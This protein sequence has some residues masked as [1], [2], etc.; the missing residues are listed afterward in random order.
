VI[1]PPSRIAVQRD[2]PDGFPLDG[3]ADVAAV[4]DVTLRNIDFTPSRLQVSKGTTVVFRWRD[5][6]T[7]HDVT[8]VGAKRFKSLGERSSGSRSV[9]FATAGTYRYVCTLHPGMD[10]RITVR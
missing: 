8:S 2:E 5:G 6:S 9:R 4:R 1:R 7:S 3:P 10:G